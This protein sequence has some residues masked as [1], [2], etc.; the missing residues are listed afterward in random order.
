MPESGISSASH[1]S[2]VW[3]ELVGGVIIARIRGKATADLVRECEMRITV[4]QKE[5]GCDRIMY[6]A[7]ELERPEIDTVL[8]QK[9][10]TAA[11]K[12]QR[13]KVSI[14]VPD[15]SIAYLARLAFC[16]A[17]HRVIYNDL[18]DAALWLREP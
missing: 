7:L 18:A 8:V 4:L 11:L 10:I 9:A 5:T 3:V 6:D 16:E 13:V 15:T 17:N 14:V 1:P 12:N 2:Q